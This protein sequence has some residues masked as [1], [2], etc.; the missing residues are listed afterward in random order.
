MLGFKLRPCGTALALV[1]LFLL[2][3]SALAGGPRY[4]AGVSSF[5]SGLQGTPLTWAQGSIAY[6][7]D[8]GSLSSQLS[9]PAA[10][11]FI[12]DAF[13]RWT[14][15]PTAAIAATRAGQLNEDVSGANVFANSDGTASLPP[16]IAPDAIGTPLAVV[17]DADGS[18]IDALVG[19]GASDPSL[20]ASN[21]VVG[22]P[23]NL[24]LDAHLAHALVI[25]N[26][27][28][29]QTAAQLPDLKYHLVRILGR[30]LGLDWS[31]VNLNVVLG[32]PAPTPADYAG[33]S[34]MH[35]MDPPFCL[36]IAKCYPANVDPS[37]P[38]L[39]DRA[40]L[41][42][43]YPSQSTSSGKQTFSA[44]SVRIHGSV[45]FED[46]NGQPA[47]PMQGVNVV[48]RWVDPSTGIP[49]RTYAIASVSGFLFRGNAG[50][51]VTGTLD[52]SGQPYDR[53]GSDDPAF[54]GFFDLAGLPIP[55]GGAT[56]QYQL[57]VETVDPVWSFD[58]QPYGS[59][60]VQPSG[61]TRVFV[62]AGLGQ[63]I[64]QD[65]LMGSSSLNTPD[66]FGATTYA[67]PAALPSSGDWTG[68][69][70]PYGDADYFWFAAQANRTLSVA[71]TA[72]DESGAPTENK[73][74]PAVGIWSLA[75]PQTDSATLS[76]GA[77][78]TQ[79]TGETRLDASILQSTNFRVGIADFRG[80]G[81][82][83]F[84]YQAHVFYGD[85]VTP[86]RAS[87]AGGTSLSLRG[88]GFR[89]A[90]TAA[91]GP[92]NAT[93]LASSSNQLLLAS[94]PGKDGIVSITLSDPATGSASAMI[95]V[96]TYGAGPSDTLNLVSGAS[97]AAPVGG[98]AASPLVVQ[99]VA[100]DGT[101][102]VAGASVFLTSSPAASLAACGGAASCTVV[103]NQ[104]GLVSTYL[105]PLSASVSTVTAQLAPASYNPPQQVQAILFGSSS[106]LDLALSPQFAWIAQ[107]ATLGLS[108][109]T[110]VLSLGKPVAGR[111]VDY[112]VMK[113]V[114]LLS[115]SSVLTNASGYASSTLQLSSFGADVQVSACVQ[116]QP[117]DSPCLSFYGTAVAGAALRLQPVSGSLQIEPLTQNFSPVI[118]QVTDSAGIHPVLGASVVFQSLVARAPQGLP[119][120]W[121]G[122]TG[123]TGHPMPVIL[124][125]SQ[126]SV[127]S[128]VNGF[129]SLQ[130]STGG[131][132]G[133]LL[134][135]G[136]ATAGA[137]ASQYTL[138]S[139]PVRVASPQAAPVMVRSAARQDIGAR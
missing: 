130:P 98:E 9:G 10:D 32:N 84:R 90:D 116:N 133:P 5:S 30:V 52:G 69:L 17:Y 1:L 109:T 63:D 13:S 37:Q 120:V 121:I 124:S 56:A 100:S 57:T 46:A 15:I 79:V 112:Q 14:S 25:L 70:S 4:V 28:C 23:D 33:F 49:S 26:G 62:T 107:G 126:I 42:Q 111:A 74:Q 131:V 87:V 44:N 129:A 11:A 91:V 117:V 24:S 136:S 82:P 54:E 73:A 66:W 85:Q 127:Q 94:P 128:D 27:N 101:T 8:Q 123:I 92:A 114:A 125:S 76:V 75:A 93:L 58:M 16:D 55:D 102:P 104:S 103:S 64:Q 61:N 132:Q 2:E 95:G 137:S 3:Q 80:D 78:N 35:E 18:V 51:P 115:S 31:Q 119:V 36:P 110:R 99:V 6:Y 122:D 88:L 108:L 134:I 113:G 21:S 118:E 7:T 29:A 138:Q 34:L 22:G 39:D 96:L 50:N 68:A 20:C 81:R 77:L 106:P 59:S 89:S 105:T 60:Q 47:Q 97:Q 135:L 65:L 40:A 45:Y 19:A 83:D 139:L 72:L 67:A 53:F 38:K 48:A 86:V 71:V 12:A 41:S 43:L